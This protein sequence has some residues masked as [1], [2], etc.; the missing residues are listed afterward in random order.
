MKG[1]YPDLLHILDLALLVDM[2]ASSYIVWTDTSVIFPGRSR[3]ERLLE[4]Y[5]KY[6]KWCEDNRHFFCISNMFSVMMVVRVESQYMCYRG[7][8]LQFRNPTW[9]QGKGSTILNANLGDQEL[10]IPCNW[11]ETLEWSGQPYDGLFCNH[12]GL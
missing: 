4:L 8:L 3:D 10:I 9:M 2:Y 11:P 1:I 5:K 7:P 6:L 12:H